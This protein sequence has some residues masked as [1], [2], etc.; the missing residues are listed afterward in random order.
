MKPV[1]FPK[2]LTPDPDRK[3]TKNHLVQTM[4]KNIL[5]FSKAVYN[6]SLSPSY[7]SILEKLKIREEYDDMT[8][9]YSKPKIIKKN[10]FHSGRKIFPEKINILNLPRLPFGKHAN[11]EENDF[12][13]HFIESFENQD[14][15]ELK[16]A[17][18]MLRI[19]KRLNR[20]NKPPVSLTPLYM[21]NLNNYMVFSTEAS[22]IKCLK[23]QKVLK[24]YDNEKSKFKL[25]ATFQDIDLNSSLDSIK[26]QKMMPKLGK[27]QFSIG[28]MEKILRP[29][30]LPA[31]SKR[32]LMLD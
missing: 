5:K 16:N 21:N 7:I 24:S 1:K 27:P 10:Q 8:E 17:N 2:Y 18:K 9:R 19:Q 3:L 28:D 20:K 15:E 6:K 11:Y 25:M 30:I 31:Y 4:S 23:N 32:S 22:D 29:E 13:K 12:K 26:K 14:T